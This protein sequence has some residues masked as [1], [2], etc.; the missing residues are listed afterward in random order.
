M[1]DEHWKLTPK[2]WEK[3]QHYKD[4]SPAWIKLHRSLL[5]DYQFH[6]LPVASRA[7]APCIW[8]LA[9]EYDKGEICASS[10]E[11]AYRLHYSVEDLTDAIK[12]LI[13]SGF[14]ITAS[15]MLAARYQHAIPEKKEE[16]RR[17]EKR[18]NS[19]ARSLA[20]ALPSGALTRE[21]GSEPA[22]PKAAPPAPV[23]YRDPGNDYRSPP[24]TKSSNTLEP[25]HLVAAKRS[26]SEE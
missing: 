17:E 26:T 11:I 5:D 20:S 10:T 4:R 12:P 19:S 13:E 9:A 24:R 16:K 18:A 7:L 1:T 25:T 23:N 8:L 15:G 22:K 2:N 14:L 3:F 21:P 6:C